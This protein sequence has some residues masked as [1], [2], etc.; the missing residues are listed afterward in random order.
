MELG[1]TLGNVIGK[2]DIS[3]RLLLISRIKKYFSFF[4]NVI[5]K[6]LSQKQDHIN[7]Q[8]VPDLLPTRGHTPEG[9]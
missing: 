6:S 2:A 4:E 3:T 9:N 7:P 5:H 8:L 1:L